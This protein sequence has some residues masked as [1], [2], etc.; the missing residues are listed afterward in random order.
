ML[1]FA[2]DYTN[3]AHPEVLQ[4]LID[5]NAQ[6]LSG[7]GTDELC[8]AAADKIRRACAREDAQVYF[9]SGGT[10][11]NQVV[12]A[13]QL[14]AYEGVIA[15]ASGHINAHEAG[16]IEYSGHKVLALPHHDGRLEAE[17]VRAYL[18]AFFADESHDHM[19]FPGM[20]YISQPTEYGTLYSKE[21]LQALYAVC[22]DY[23]LPLFI[24]GARL[25]YALTSPENDVTLPQLAELCDVFSVG[26]TKVGALCGEAVVFP[27]G[28]SPLQF[29]T[30]VKQHG[31]MLAKGRL[32]GAQF[33]ALFT[34]DLYARIGRQVIDTA[35]QLKAVF[36]Q[37]GYRFHVDS[38]TNQQFVVLDNETLERL[39]S[40]VLF[41]VWE[42]VDEQHT[43]V[44]FATG[45]TTTREDINK[46]EALL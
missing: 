23:Q 38:P 5:T 35:M 42:T 12:I 27:H 28:N 3:G 15:A 46:L 18:E 4:R 45:W 21:Q 29:N 8:A 37:K 31:A 2:S 34:N 44:R 22:R 41:T 17:E 10:Q 1:S 7:Y 33:D 13:A 25:A 9:L 11:T 20:V 39:R 36:A 30:I 26:G 19:V 6:I 32:L 14:R 16:A 24:D 43:A 40:Q